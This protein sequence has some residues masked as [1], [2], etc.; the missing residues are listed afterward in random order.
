M[1]IVLIVGCACKV[2]AA[3]CLSHFQRPKTLKHSIQCDRNE[4]TSH[5]YSCLC[6]ATR[7]PGVVTMQKSIGNQGDVVMGKHKAVVLV[8]LSFHCK[9]Q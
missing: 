1:A 4:S 8:E 6:S 2:Y 5:G 9:L 7:I 3:L